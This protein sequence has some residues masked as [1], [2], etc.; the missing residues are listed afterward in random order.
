M[1]LC[2]I[3]PRKRYVFILLERGPYLTMTVPQPDNPDPGTLQ[4][5]EWTYSPVPGGGEGGGV[6]Q[7]SP[8]ED[9]LD[10]PG[11]LTDPW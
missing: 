8:H 1:E 3:S 9:K 4:A 6:R 10:V 2:Y 7:R 11:T 5:V